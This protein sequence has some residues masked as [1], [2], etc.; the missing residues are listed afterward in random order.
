MPLQRA[1]ATTGQFEWT[2]QR[3]ETAALV[4]ADDLTNVEICKRVGICIKTLANWKHTREFA[5]RVE[6]HL[7]AYRAAVRSRGIA[8]L[9]RRVDSLDDR[10]DRM[11]RV[12]D[13]RAADGALAGV[14]GGSTGLVVKH[15][16]ATGSGETFQL[17][18]EYEVDVDL[19]KELREHEKQAAQELGQWVENHRV[20]QVTKAYI[21]VGPD[22]L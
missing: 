20:E 9:E 13:E 16:K 22:E 15:T 3:E 10:W 14:P 5:N 18:E 11:K 21:V 6:E 17:I 12:I 2:P 8:R 19:L 1:N 7:A 4:A